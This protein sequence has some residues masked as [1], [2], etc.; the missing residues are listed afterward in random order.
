MTEVKQMLGG[1]LA[2]AIE[3]DAHLGYALRLLILL[4]VAEHNGKSLLEILRDVS[5]IH[6][7]AHNNIAIDP[8]APHTLHLLT[9]QLEI[10]VGIAKERLVV[11][12]TGHLLDRLDN[13]GIKGI[14]NGGKNQ[15]DGKGLV[16]I[17]AA[18]QDIG[19]ITHLF[20]TL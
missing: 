1:K 15:S 2:S 19:A 8:A 9:C 5:N 13:F 16:V 6:T 20:R 10:I 11:V 4:P 14:G 12:L 7:G 18:R 3:I 17:E